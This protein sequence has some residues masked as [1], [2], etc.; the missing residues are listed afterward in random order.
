MGSNAKELTTAAAQ[1]LSS[2]QTGHPVFVGEGALAA[3][4]RQF[5][6]ERTS[7]GPVTNWPL[8]LRALTSA[9]LASR[10]P[11]L[12]FWGPE[13]VMIY[14]DAFAPS[15]GSTRDARGLGAKGREFWTDVWP[16]VGP[17]IE[18]VL[19]RGESHW[20]ENT[21]VPIEREGVLDE[22]WWTYSYSPVRDDRGDIA[23]CLVICQEVTASVRAE[24]RLREINHEL[25]VERARLSEVFEKAPSFFAMLR[26]PDFR[27]EMA[28]EAYFGLIG[29]HD[30]IGKPLLEAI[31]EIASQGFRDLLE[32]VVTTGE[33]FVGREAL[34]H[35]ANR[36]GR[37][38]EDR[39]VDFIYQAIVEADGSR[40]GAFVHGYDVTDHVMAR[41]A[42][43]QA[44]ADRLRDAEER[45]RLLAVAEDARREAESANRAKSDFLAV[46]SHEL[47]T[48]LNA[49]DG[50][51]EL[52]EM[53][54]HGPL[55]EQQ[56]QYLIRI[57]KSQRHLLGLINGV[58]NYTRVEAGA[59]QYDLNAVSLIDVLASCDALMRPQ[60]EHRHLDFQVDLCSADLK[61]VADAE[62]LQQILLNLLT[63]ASKFTPSRGRVRLS[64]EPGSESVAITV[65]DTGRGIPPEQAARI[66]EP[67][68]QVDARLTRTEEGVGLGLAISRD[69]AHGMQGEITLV[70]E[71]GKGSAFTVTIPRA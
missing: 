21:L 69:L 46:M 4:C 70:S 13:L 12:L 43:E 19:E 41:R 67:F 55:T 62:K 48:P 6:W 20:F 25:E 1:G 2:A 18:G 38:P 53:E 49:I 26:G 68:V 7:L 14:N 30:V 60:M 44:A 29:R 17:Q 47:R 23:G 5:D 31:P 16:A 66:F 34:V 56:R 3:R 35:F 42:V 39:Y 10:N 28:N 15:L 27:I 24:A 64:C 50:Y 11:I 54:V 52:M 40:S 59:A 45:A 71:V 37:G 63:N 8:S 61:V 65:E 58:L 22:A 9:L 57:R 51:A 33:P 36:G 32:R